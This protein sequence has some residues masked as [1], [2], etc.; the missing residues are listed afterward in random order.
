MEPVQINIGIVFVYYLIIYND[1]KR[2]HMYVGISMVSVMD[3]EPGSLKTNVMVMDHDKK[4]QTSTLNKK[5][6]MFR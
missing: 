2:Q 3:H 5:S 4:K 6:E 1:V